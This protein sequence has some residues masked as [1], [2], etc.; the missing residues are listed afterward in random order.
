MNSHMKATV[1]AKIKSILD[2]LLNLNGYRISPNPLVSPFC[3]R[4]IASD[5][6]YLTKYEAAKANT[7]STDIVRC[8]AEIDFPID[9]DWLDELALQ[10]QVTIKDSPLNYRH[11][12]I[13]YSYLVKYI[14]SLDLIDLR[15]P[16]I[17]I[18][19]TGTARGFS[20]L[21]MAKALHDTGTSG[22][23]LTVDPIP[24]NVP[25][26]WNAIGDQHGMRSRA[27][28]ISKWPNLI[29][30]I[31][32]IC[33]YLP[34]DLNRI[35]LTRINFAFLD[36]QHT[37]EDVLAE[38]SFVASLQIPGDIIVFDDV[39]P[40]M[41]DGVVLALND[42]EASGTYSI[43]YIKSSISRSYAVGIKN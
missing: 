39:T 38:F 15:N 22:S 6:T 37:Y 11:G 24:H 19:E 26:Y 1:K 41:F 28:L 9:P 27:D 13:L 5:D 3:E 42:I 16:H 14:K 2:R 35:G 40:N 31:Q 34:H 30:R 20:A 17:Q 25:M 21:C 4:P 32:F 7:Y 23:I 12:M 29:Q 10:T 8:K 36:A 43:S 18:F 33:G